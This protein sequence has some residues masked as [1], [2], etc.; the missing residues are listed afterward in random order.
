MDINWISPS[1]QKKKLKKNKKLNLTT[2]SPTHVVLLYDK[3]IYSIIEV[4]ALSKQ[5]HVKYGFKN[6]YK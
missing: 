5:M 6:Q 2:R 1:S 3:M 4:V